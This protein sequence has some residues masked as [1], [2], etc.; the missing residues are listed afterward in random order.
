MK[1]LMRMSR[2]AIVALLFFGLGLI[3]PV[4]ADFVV[5]K[6]PTTELSFVLQGKSTTI[7]SQPLMTFV[8]VTKQTFE[9][10]KGAGTEV[11]S[12]PL[13][14][15]IASKK[16]SSAK[17]NEEELLAATVWALDHGQIPEF[18]RGLEQL[19]ASNASHPFG[20]HAKQLKEELAKPIP[21]DPEAEAA[22]LK[23]PGGGDGKIVK[24]AHFIALVPPVV[25]EKGAVKRKK[26]EARLEQFE[27][28]LEIFVMKCAE[29]G[30]PVHA[31][32]ARMHVA[33]VAGALSA[34]DTGLRTKARDAT[35][36]WSPSQNVLFLNDGAKIGALNGLKKLQEKVSE[37][38]TQPSS[39][40]NQQGGQPG[41]AAPGA[42]MAPGGAGGGMEMLNQLSTTQLQK[43]ETS[44]NALM[45]IGVENF[46]LESIS[47]ETAYYF[48]SSCGVFSAT[49]PVWLRDGL[50]TY[51]EL[52]ADLGWV[53]VGDVG[54]VRQSWYLAGLQDPDRISLSDI[55]C[56]HCYEPPMSPNDAMRATTQ[57]WALV[58]FLLERHPEGITKFV[59]GL[60]SLPPDL[61]VPEEVTMG[62]FDDAFGGERTKLDESWREHVVALKPAYRA[63]KSDGDDSSTAQ[64]SN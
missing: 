54:H 14:K 23:L 51:F 55:V 17:T 56:G 21:E 43:L 44:L 12:V 49:A 26:P 63:L 31:P 19:L 16:L 27:H 45:A 20:T 64:S 22:L 10:P 57:S 34:N 18:H 40:R 39:R 15:E 11:I 38:V 6:V 5:F 42:G 25:V 36:H 33:L 46:E 59:A 1:H 62:I 48:T 37:L 53:K 3:A 9:L 52:P 47:R 32:Q 50:A 4:N 30:L 58:H 29:R 60:R 41:G 2:I 7:K 61:Q 8:S 24:S 28:L 13:L 35:I